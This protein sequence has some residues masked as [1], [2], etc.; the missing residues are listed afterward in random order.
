VGALPS[1]ALPHYCELNGRVGWRASDLWDL[2]INALN[3][4]HA[5]HY[6][7][8]PAAGGEGIYRSVMAEAR[9]RF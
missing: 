5:R 2:S 8:S 1:P 6:E 4:L 3:L 9:L 7:F